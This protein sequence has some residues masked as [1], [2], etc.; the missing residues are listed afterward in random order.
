MWHFNKRALAILMVCAILAVAIAGCSGDPESQSTPDSSKDPA[1]EVQ[2]I[3]FMYWGSPAEKAAV[4]N[5]IKTFE[6]EHQNIKVEGINVPG[7]DYYTKLSAMIAGNEAPDISY[8]GPWKLQLGEDGV[9]YEFNELSE[10]YPE[11]MPDGLIQFCE[12][13]WAPG[14]SAGPFQSTVTPSLMYN[15]EIFVEAGVDLPP[16]K[17]EDAWSWDEFVD[18]AKKL[19]LDDQGRNAYNP[20]FDSE[21]I[22]QYGIKMSTAWYVYMT[23]VLSNGGD[24]LSEDGTEFGLNK[25]EATEALQKIADLIN[26]HKVHPTLAQ[27]SSIPAPA[28]ALQSRRVAMTIDGSWCHADLSGTTMDWGVGVL[29]QMGDSY[30]TYFI[31][32]SLIIFKSTEKLDAACKFYNWITDPKRVLEMHQGLWMPQF[33]EWYTDETLIEQWASEDLPGRPEGFQD[34]VMRSTFEHSVLG[35]EQGVKNFPEID[36]LV[37]AALDDLWAGNKT[38]QE[39]MDGVLPVVEPLIEGW[40][41]ER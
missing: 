38:A 16:T 4:E 8:S 30:K 15:K 11:M 40:Y 17:V 12:W 7:G 32:G 22:K 31:G 9:I 39:V 34:A 27:S 33:S 10:T 1:E 35:A 20:E 41:F 2:T 28:T 6:A 24:Y 18:A 23:M 14:K 25:P 19:T 36:A 3:R 37:G 26:V 5:A 21:N 29:P 13:Q